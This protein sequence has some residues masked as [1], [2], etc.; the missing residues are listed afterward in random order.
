MTGAN[1]PRAEMGRA[2][3][4][5]PSA[6]SVRHGHAE[7]LSLI[8]LLVALAVLSVGVLA[9]ALAQVGALRVVGVAG[10]LRTAAE[11]VS[12]ELA[13]VRSVPRAL[14]TSACQAAASPPGGDG[15]SC[16]LDLVCVRTLEARCRVATA[17]VV[18]TTPDATELVATSAVRWAG[19]PASTAL[20]GGVAGGTP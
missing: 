5:S 7:G 17:R 3:V 2:R 12:G 20:P 18:V 15:W 14:G 4:R 11:L 6:P 8:E 19:P 10:S 9:L 13:A 16:T 1:Q